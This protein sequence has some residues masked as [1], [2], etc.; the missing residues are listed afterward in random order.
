V[1]GVFVGPGDLATSQGHAGQRMHRT[2]VAAVEDAIKRIR[3]AASPPASR[4]RT[5]PSPHA[6]SSWAPCSPWSAPISACS[7]GTEKL[8]AQ[9]KTA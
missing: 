6:A 3:A 8:A 9:F 7:R 1:D 4:R 5:M 2:V